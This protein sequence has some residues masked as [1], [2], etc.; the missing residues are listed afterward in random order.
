MKL[1]DIPFNDRRRRYL[2]FHPRKLPARLALASTSTTEAFESVG[3]SRFYTSTDGLILAKVVRDKFCQRREPFKWL[4]RDYLEKRW[5]GQSDARKEYLS[6]RILKRAGL[7][8]P[9]F[10]GWGISLNPANRNASLLLMEHIQGAE[11]GGDVVFMRADEATRE[12]LL[13][14]VAEEVLMLAKAGY[15]HRDLHLNNLLVTDNQELIWVDAHL[16]PM[17]KA[18]DK[19]WP[20]LK[21]TLSDSKFY[22]AQYRQRIQRHLEDAWR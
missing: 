8:T 15:L 18:R 10:H 1:L 19:R 9:R 2:V 13:D 12:K 14:R 11:M 7:R 16:K 5:L 4:T 6:M 21:A 20:A 17:P 3:S 22:G